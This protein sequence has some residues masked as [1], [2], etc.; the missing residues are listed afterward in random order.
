AP[1]AGRPLHGILL[2]DRMAG[3]SEADLQLSVSASRPDKP[4]VDQL[5]KI[6][7]VPGQSFAF[8]KVDPTIQR[9]LVSAREDAQELMVWAVPTL[10][11]AANYWQMNTNTMGVYGNYYLKRAIIAQLGL[12]ANVPEDAIY[13]FNMGT[14]PASRSMGPT[15]THS[16]SQKV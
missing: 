14:R 16:T 11:R 3:S 2:A 8:D 13:P 5:R 15:N 1:D 10:G 6:G 4:M 9:A 7:I 12:G